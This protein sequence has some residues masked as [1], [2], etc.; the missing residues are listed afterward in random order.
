MGRDW[1]W[2]KGKEGEMELCEGSVTDHLREESKA[3]DGLLRH[4]AELLEFRD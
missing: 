4:F 3:H 2:E 1:H